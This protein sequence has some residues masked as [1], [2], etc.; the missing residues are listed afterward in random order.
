MNS[1]IKLIALDIDGTIMNKQF[2]I[3]DKTKT[4][5]LKAINSGIYVVLATGRMY[6]ATV[7]IAQDLGIKTPLI[8]YQGSLIKEFYSSDKVLLNYN[9][10]THHSKN[11]IDE[12]RKFDAQINVYMND[13]LYVEKE[14]DILTE[15]AQ[16]RYIKYHKVNSFDDIQNLNPVKILA[17]N[18]TSSKTTEMKNHLEKKYCEAL[19]IVKSTHL[20]CEIINNLASKGNALLHLAKMWGIKQSEIMAIGDQDNDKDMLAT[21]GFPVAM[22]NGDECLKQL[23]KYI[24]CTVD[25]DGAAKAIEKFALELPDESAI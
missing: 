2:Q 16:K 14:S 21:A 17:I 8:T 10:S 11:I 4:V 22:E 20:Y 23:A 3:S 15:Y 6:S 25:N 24:T 12:L 7:P 18:N 9:I 1:E 13:E 5:I 19:N